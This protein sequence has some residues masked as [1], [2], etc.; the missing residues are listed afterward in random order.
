MSCMHKIGVVGDYESVCGFS[1][2]GLDTF[3]AEDAQSAYQIVKRLVKNTYAIIYVI[4]EYAQEMPELYEKYSEMQT[5]AIVP[6]PSAR[7]TNGFGMD[8]V[9]RSVNRAVGSD[10]IFNQN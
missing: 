4:E 2:L 3:C 7:G 10:I 1:A 5:P 6:I 8:R 9:K